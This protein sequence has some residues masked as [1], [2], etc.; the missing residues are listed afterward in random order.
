MLQQRRNALLLK[1]TKS[2]WWLMLALTACSNQAVYDSLK[3]QQ[4]YECGKLPLSQQQAC[5]D[6]AAKPYSDYQQ[7]QAAASGS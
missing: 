6:D 7:E 3:A 4:R 5:F 1:R 2:L